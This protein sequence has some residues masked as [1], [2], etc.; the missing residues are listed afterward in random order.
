MKEF[1]KKLE[2]NK[3]L[4]GF[5]ENGENRR[6]CIWFF[7]LITYLLLFFIIRNQFVLLF[8][9][10]I[11]YFIYSKLY[12]YLYNRLKDKISFSTKDCK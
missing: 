6:L 3:K 1:D 7:T 9:Y 2:N 4:L 5:M 10:F 11:C 8:S 12:T